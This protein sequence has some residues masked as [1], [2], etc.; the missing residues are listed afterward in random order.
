ML[1]VPRRRVSAEP[2]GLAAKQRG[3]EHVS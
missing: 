2:A 3:H 1:C